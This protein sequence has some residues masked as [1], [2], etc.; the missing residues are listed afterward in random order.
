MTLSGRARLAG[1]MG[2]PVGHSRSPRLHGY[3]LAHYRIDGAYVPLPV[4]PEDLAQAL[5]ALPIL[6]FAGVNLTIPHKERAAALMDRL[7]P[8]ARRIG[9]VN[10]VIVRDSEL[11][12][13]NTDGYG[14]LES[15]KET[16]PDW[17][18]ASGPA[19]VLGAGGTAR[20]VIAALVDAG[21]PE[22]RLANRTAARGDAIAEGFG[23]AIRIYAWS[24]RAKALEGAALLVNTTSLGMIGAPALEFALEGL[25]P[26]AVVSDVVYTPLETEL[27]AAARARGHPVV[28][29]LGMLLHQARPGFAAWFG[30]TPQVTPQLR[31]FVLQS[32]QEAV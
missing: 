22:I 24:D 10:T 4:A 13:D 18:A 17:R 32:L 26:G 21:V 31:T 30:V 20:A 6:S 15:I 19:L 8:A 23:G 11:I 28:D 7:E 14:F 27:L 12:G 3:W 16:V 9:A 1:V 29:G 5:K 2:W 25:P